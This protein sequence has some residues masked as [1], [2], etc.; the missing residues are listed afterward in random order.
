MTEEAKHR[1]ECEIPDAEM[2]ELEKE[3]Q[4]EVSALTKEDRKHLQ[5]QKDS[6]I[7]DLLRKIQENHNMDFE[8]SEESGAVELDLQN[9]EEPAAEGTLTLEEEWKQYLEEPVEENKDETGAEEAGDL[10]SGNLFNRRLVRKTIINKNPNLM[11]PRSNS[12][13]PI[14]IIKTPIYDLLI[15]K[16]NLHSYLIR[17][18]E[19]RKLL[20]D[21]RKKLDNR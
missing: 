14:K 11:I 2:E 8:C 16:F 18:Y 12:D 19:F 17:E 9:L 15:E 6:E 7:D 20:M 5:R 3:I 21:C 4:S 1:A 10:D 13:V